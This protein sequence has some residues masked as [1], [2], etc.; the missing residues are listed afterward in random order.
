MQKIP[1][2]AAIGLLSF[3]GAV[4]AS[5]LVASTDTLGS[6]LANSVEASSDGTSSSFG[7]DKV[8]L[9]ARDDAAS[10][11]GSAGAV[12]GVYLEAALQHIR[13][14]APDLQATDMQLAEA[15]LAL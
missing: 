10:Y 12:R 1:F 5:S 11:V 3:A 15:I 9:N 13:Q 7:S 14:Q 8:V 2:I 4:S 6:S